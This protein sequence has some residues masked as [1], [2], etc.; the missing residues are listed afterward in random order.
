[1]SSHKTHSSQNCALKIPA[2]LLLHIFSSGRLLLL[3]LCLSASCR[4][5]AI[6]RKPGQRWGSHIVFSHL[7]DY[8]LVLPAILNV[9]TVVFCIQSY[10]QWEG[11]F[12]KLHCH[13]WKQKYNCYFWT[14][15]KNH[16]TSYFPSTKIHIYTSSSQL[17]WLLQCPSMGKFLNNNNSYLYSSFQCLKNP[18]Q[19]LL[20]LFLMTSRQFHTTNKK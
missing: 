16:R 11:M 20:D 6:G 14:F 19:I 9:K 13:K 15:E 7:K 4:E 8:S 3:G 10:F 1:M 18:L 12:C 17:P 2:P 5:I